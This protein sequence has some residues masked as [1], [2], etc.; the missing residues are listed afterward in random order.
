MPRVSPMGQSVAHMVAAGYL[1][2]IVERHVGRTTTHDLFGM[3]DL[4][5]IRG[6]ETVGVQC[7]DTTN[8]AARCHKIAASPHAAAVRGAGWRMVVHGW[9]PDG[10]L[11]EV[12]V[13]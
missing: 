5:A 9:Y 4:V 10:R 7:T 1:V 12:D 11:R 6:R 13:P 3:F 8:V 2:D